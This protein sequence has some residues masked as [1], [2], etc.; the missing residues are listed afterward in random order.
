M[1]EP[2]HVRKFFAHHMGASLPKRDQALVKCTFH[3]DARP[4]LSIN[5]QDGVWKCQAGCGDGGLI[6]FEMLASK[7][8]RDTAKRNIATIVGVDLFGSGD[9]QPEAVYQ[10]RNALG[11]VVF[12]KLRLPGKVFRQRRKNTK[13]GYDYNLSGVQKPLYNL[14]DLITAN[15]VI[16]VEGEKDADNGTRAFAGLPEDVK[17]GARIAVTTNFDGAGKWADHYNAYFSGKKTV[18][19]ADNDQVGAEHA[20]RVARAI[21][22]YAAGVKIVNLPDLPDKGDV[23]DYLE[24]HTAQDLLAEIA[25]TAPWFPPKVAQELFAPAPRFLST[26][27]DEIDWMIERVIQRGANGMISAIPK[28]G[29]SWASADMAIALALGEP[30]LG[31]RVPR[32]VKVAFVSREDAP[33]LTQWRMKNLWRGRSAKNPSLIE[34]NLYVNTQMQ[35]PLLLLDDEAQF[36][37]LMDAMR[38]FKPE[39]AIFDVFNVLHT[40][41]ENDNS[42]MRA[43]LRQLSRIRDEIGCGVLMIHHYNKQ[44]EQTNITQRMRGASAIGGW[45]EF[46]IGIS[47]HDEVTRTRR[48]QFETKAAEP[49]EPVLYRI[50][51][52]GDTSTLK[53]ENAA[54]SKPVRGEYELPV[55]VG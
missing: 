51:S 16:V 19:L 40:A 32:P 2:K 8:D 36:T 48:A 34:T 27:A 15:V 55:A 20:Q 13:G 23:S 7:C 47:M 52:T 3:D 39:F 45:C 22:S 18:I 6:E 33:A 9:Q 35:S 1:I 44:A 43:V 38:S 10:Y 50:V 53:V 17:K 21:H 26:V 49:P 12:E 37:E 30:W 54:A 29:K 28:A 42:E 31:F 11:N 5:L 25:K 14:P 46:V 24:S 41:D 4:S